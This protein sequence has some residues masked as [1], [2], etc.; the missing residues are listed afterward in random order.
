MP[1][2]I[3]MICQQTFGQES[4]LRRHQVTHTKD[5]PH[6]CSFCSQTF[7]QL[8]SLNRHKR[9]HKLEIH[10]NAQNVTFLAQCRVT[11]LNI[12]KRTFQTQ[13][14][15]IFVQS[16]TIEPNKRLSSTDI[17][18]VSIMRLKIISV[19]S[20]SLKLLG[21]TASK[22]TLKLNTTKYLKSQI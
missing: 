8:G 9:N 10:I 14:K 7:S 18:K 11:Y 16:A 4:I 6:L 13:R 15:S 21:W 12:I 20:V 2:H 22:D 17:K 3:R 19:P 1:S 5:K